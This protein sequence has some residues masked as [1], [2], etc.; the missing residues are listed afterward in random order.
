M[1]LYL[2][3]KTETLQGFDQ[4]AIAKR[5]QLAICYLI[6]VFCFCMRERKKNTLA[7][8]V[9]STPGCCLFL[10]L[11]EEGGELNEPVQQVKD[12]QSKKIHFRGWSRLLRDVRNQL[13]NLAWSNDVNE[14]S[15]TTIG[16]KN[17]FF[18][19]KDRAKKIH[20]RGQSRPLR[21]VIYSRTG[22]ESSS[23]S[24]VGLRI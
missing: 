3:V 10:V 23:M 19:V 16:L 14:S 13:N 2:Q 17:V 12:M 7:H 18:G 6:N 15:T 1:K 8:V 20:F 22:D 4:Q 9:K 11:Y 24:T 5:I 21:D